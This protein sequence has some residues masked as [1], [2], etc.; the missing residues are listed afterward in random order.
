MI[1]VGIAV[2]LVATVTNLG[3]A[4]KAKYTSVATALK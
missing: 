1:A 2:M 3:S 4:G